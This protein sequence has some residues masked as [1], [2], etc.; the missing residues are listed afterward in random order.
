MLVRHYMTRE[1]THFTP[2]TPCREA[3]QLFHRYQIRHAP[4]LKGRELVGVVTER[5]LLKLLPSTVADLD[6]E[7]GRREEKATVRRAMS[8][9]PRTIGPNTW[10]EDAAHVLII[11]R[12]GCLLV[13]DEGE[14]VGIATSS[15]LFQALVDATSSN[16][17]RRFSWRRASDQGH[18]DIAL[19]CA[20]LGLELCGLIAHGDDNHDYLVARVRGVA[21]SYGALVSRAADAGFQLFATDEDAQR[22]AG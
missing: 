8:L 9:H 3:L 11:Q 15:D 5:D 20:E 19:A 10:I 14:L 6:S 2:D 17:A 18:F 7:R 22:L 21:S 13:V 16:E 1:I 12:I 4:V